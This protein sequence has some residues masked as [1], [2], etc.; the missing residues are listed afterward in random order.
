MSN[1]MPVPALA[2]R[3]YT[4]HRACGQL[5]R[6]AGWAA[7]RHADQSVRGSPTGQVQ[8]RRKV[9]ARTT[10][11][12]IVGGA[13][14]PISAPVALVLGRPD[15]HGRLRVVGR[16]TPIPRH[17]RTEVG[18]HMRPA[19]ATHP[20]PLVLLPSR[21]GDSAPVEY[22]RVEPSLV[23][24]PAVDAAIDIV[25]GRPFWRHPAKLQR[26]RLDLNPGDLSGVRQFSGNPV[27]RP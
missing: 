19:G 26:V 8:I 2:M 18:A 13:L 6:S 5:G 9:R 11:E 1:V 3:T 23:V 10:T 25:R 20:W 24:E 27:D 16:T 22:S 14:G 7:D 17:L 21:Y 12:A 4:D 15:M